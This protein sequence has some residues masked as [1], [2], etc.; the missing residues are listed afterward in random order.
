[1]CS[2]ALEDLTTLRDEV[3]KSGAR[4]SSP[5][6]MLEQRTWLLHWA[7]FV[8]FGDPNNAPATR[9]GLQ[10][11]LDIALSE[12]YISTI[13]HNC[14][15]LLR[16]VTVAAIFTPKRRKNNLRDVC[17]TLN[18]CEG[19]YSDAFTRFVTSVLVDFD[20]DE[21]QK[22]LEASLGLLPDDPFLGALAGDFGETA[23]L[24]VFETYCR[25]HSKIDIGSLAQKL[26]MSSD[27]AEV[28]IVNL[29]RNR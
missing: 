11:F 25:L 14:P 13:Q 3:E 2:Q 18:V 8:C 5:L 19:D 29:I 26:G 23:R 15:H 10:N 12:K 27:D 7:V 1:M 21:A 28:W 17:A 20:F 16:Y 22:Q 4:E 9:A 6:V 24:L